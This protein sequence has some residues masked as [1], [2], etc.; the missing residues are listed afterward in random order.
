[1]RDMRVEVYEHHHKKL[2]PHLGPLVTDRRVVKDLEGPV[3]SGEGSTWLL[4]RSLPHGHVLGFASL[5]DD[6]DA[7]WLDYAWVEPAKREQGVFSALAEERI[8]L[9]GRKIPKPVRTAVREARWG[10]Y[11][12]R[13]FTE[14]RRR[15]RWVYG[16]WSGPWT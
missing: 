10:H 7:Y 15:G 8:S 14:L 6:G 9:L 1:M 12:E 16:E 5:R 13:G 4:A 11:Q 2:W 3:F